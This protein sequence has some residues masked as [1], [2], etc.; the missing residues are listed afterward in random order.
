MG[1]RTQQRR[2]RPRRGGVGEVERRAGGGGAVGGG[3]A[4]K[5]VVVRATQIR[6]TTAAHAAG[7]VNVVVTNP[8]TQSGT[9]TNGYTYTSASAPTVTSVSPS[10]GAAAGGTAVTI[11][12]TNFVTGAT[13]TFGGTGATNVVVVSATQITAT[14]AAHAAGAVNVVV[15]NPDTQ[16]GSLTNGYTYVAAPTVGSVSPSSGAAAGGTAVTI[17]GTN[18]VTGATAT[19]GGTGATNVRA[20]SAK[21]T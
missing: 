14:T 11:T 12:G 21:P 13:A 10:S 4:E 16:S 19:F 2:R 3:G 7:A 20:R 6:A 9:L 18:F 8:D 15:T 5:V 1:T 17:T